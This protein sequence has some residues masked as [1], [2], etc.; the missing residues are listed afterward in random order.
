M[1]AI[2]TRGEAER[3]EARTPNYEPWLYCV[4]ETGDELSPMLETTGIRGLATTGYFPP[5]M[6]L[7]NPAV[8]EVVCCAATPLTPIRPM[9]C[10]AVSNRR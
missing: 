9:S 6:H 3:K 5:M 4:S 1:S 2:H 7:W 8:R 10:V